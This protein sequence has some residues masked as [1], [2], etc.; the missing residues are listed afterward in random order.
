MVRQEPQQI[1]VILH[2]KCYQSPVE[3]V[4]NSAS[5]SWGG[6]S[7]FSYWDFVSYPL[8]AANLIFSVSLSALAGLSVSLT[9]ILLSLSNLPQLDPGMHT[10]CNLWACLLPSLKHFW[11]P[12]PLKKP[13]QRLQSLALSPIVL[14]V[15]HNVF[16][17]WNS[18]ACG[19]GMSLCFPSGPSLPAVS[20]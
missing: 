4:I 9:R 10:P 3:G 15:G 13:S 11:L 12:P 5:F 1:T 14:F 19:L 20:N 8:T 17:S 18:C 2:R 6:F 16:K 7:L